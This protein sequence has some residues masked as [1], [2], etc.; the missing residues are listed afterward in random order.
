MLGADR[1]HILLFA[2]LQCSCIHLSKP[3]HL[4]SSFE[5]E[6]NKL[7]EIHLFIWWL[8]W[9]QILP[10]YW[11]PEFKQTFTGL[12]S[13]A[14]KKSDGV[15]FS[16]AAVSPPCGF[17]QKSEWFSHSYI[18]NNGH[19]IERK[20]NPS[21]ILWTRRRYVLS[22]RHLLR[23]TTDPPPPTHTHSR[24]EELTLPYFE[25][26]KPCSLEE[27]TPVRKETCTWTAE[28]C[29]QWWRHRWCRIF[30]TPRFGACIPFQWGRWLPDPLLRST[31]FDAIDG[32]LFNS[33]IFWCLR[34]WPTFFERLENNA[35]YHTPY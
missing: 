25:T 26:S 13:T 6:W 17:K 12:P 20:K 2:P 28:H 3:V 27:T 34:Q 5:A 10:R 9:W 7:F 1:P 32:L 4:L 11:V 8:S 24:K 19:D 33:S 35:L 15:L 30:E 16:S 31:C 29:F 22:L 23:N 14:F 21:Q 18:I